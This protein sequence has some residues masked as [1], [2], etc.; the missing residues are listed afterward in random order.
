MDREA[1]CA[2]IHGVAESWTQLSDWTELNWLSIWCKELT[3]WKR[4]RCWERLR[5]GGEGDDRGWDSWMASPTQWRW[6][7]VNSRS[8]QWTGRPGTLWSMG[9]QRVRHDWAAELNWT[10]QNYN[11]VSLHTGLN[12][13]HQKSGDGAERRE[14]SC[15]VVGNVNWYNHYGEQ[16]ESSLEN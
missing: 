11:E 7:W 16:Y 9:L 4:P 14:P 10:D 3:H 5:A 12:G 2:V 8:W 15:T 13:H 6:V 1:W